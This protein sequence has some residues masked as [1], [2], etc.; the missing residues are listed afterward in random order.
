MFLELF[1]L[2]VEV[3]QFFRFFEFHFFQLSQSFLFSLFFQFYARPIQSFQHG[4]IVFQCQIIQ[5]TRF[6]V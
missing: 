4:L 6:L 5:Q 2:L 3:F 1:L